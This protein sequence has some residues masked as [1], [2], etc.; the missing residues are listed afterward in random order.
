MGMIL[1]LNAFATIYEKKD[2]GVVSFSNIQT[3]GSTEVNLS[4]HPITIMNANNDESSKT[5]DWGG[6]SQNQQQQNPNE[7]TLQGAFPERMT[8]NYF[9]FYGRNHHYESLMSS[10]S[11]GDYYDRNGVNNQKLRSNY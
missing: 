11:D 4:K 10:T 1:S 5:I 3:S 6:S 8:N 7:N 9:D 2:D